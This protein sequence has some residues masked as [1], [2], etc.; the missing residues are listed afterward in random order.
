MKKIKYIFLIVILF[1]LSSCGPKSLDDVGVASVDDFVFSNGVLVEYLGN[2]RYLKIPDSYEYNGQSYDVT[3]IGEYAFLNNIQ[4]EEFE[5]PASIVEIREGAFKNAKVKKI[6]FKESSKLERI[7]QYV[8]S[9]CTSLNEIELPNSLKYISPDAFPVTE[10]LLEHANYINNGYYL[11][12]KENESLLLIKV[13]N[14][15]NKFNF[16]PSTRFIL[17]QAFYGC[18]ISSIVVPGTIENIPSQT[19]VSCSNLKNIEFQEGV[20]NISD[21]FVSRCRALEL[22]SFPNTI[23]Y[24]SPIVYSDSMKYNEYEGGLY[25]G[26]ESNKYIALIKISNLDIEHFET[27]EQTKFINDSAFSQCTKLKSIKLSDQI[28]TLPSCNELSSLEEINIPTSI[29]K[30]KNK[31]FY[32]CVS[33]K[34]IVLPNNIV[35]IESNAFY[36]CSSLKYVW[37]PKSVTY[38]EL[39]AFNECPNLLEIE[40]EEDNPCYVSI[41]GVLY[42]DDMRVLIQYNA[43]ST[44]S[45]FIMPDSVEILNSKAF[46]YAVNLEKIVMSNNITKIETATFANT[47]NLKTINLSDKLESIE[48]LA[49]ENSGLEII[50]LPETIEII[51]HY[52]FKGC[53]NL[54]D[55]TIPSKVEYL[56]NG[57]FQSCTSLKEVLI[58]GDIMKAQ[59]DAFEDCTAIDAVYYSKDVTTLDKNL[60]VNLDIVNVYIDDE[61]ELYCSVD[62]IVYNKDITSIIWY[63]NGRSD[64]VYTIQDTIEVIDDYAFSGANFT[65]LIIPQSVTRINYCAFKNCKNLQRIMIRSTI[66]EIASY[67]FTGCNDLIIYT[68]CKEIQAGWNDLWRYNLQTE[69]YIGVV[70]NH[71]LVE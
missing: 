49:F 21:D 47:T 31:Q 43:A 64:E 51:N 36:N 33:L 9:S 69:S 53:A 22:I 16:T 30:I 12:S 46:K 68:D 63:P 71:E 44:N 27:L 35:S 15:I 3:A 1:C 65:K 32:K 13:D 48:N 23:E 56:G 5:I 11:G 14:N 60:F 54:T 24:L 19:F 50:E 45:E 38:I 10:A 62:G 18:N 26:N 42:N 4:T 29:T 70:W 58:S 66:V 67:I 61:N 40:V 39:N 7:D 8:F 6:V 17:S 20:K 25:L 34:S 37:I 55:V 52:A 41:D 2:D 57:A 59:D 28:K